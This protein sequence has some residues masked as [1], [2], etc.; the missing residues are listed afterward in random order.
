MNCFAT[1]LKFTSYKSLDSI[2]LTPSGG[3]FSI[4]KEW[5]T[6][7]GLYD[8]GME[9]WGGENIELS[10]RW[11][12]NP[13]PS[14]IYVARPRRRRKER[15]PRSWPLRRIFL[16]PSRPF[17]SDRIDKRIQDLLHREKKEKERQE[18]EDWSDKGIKSVVFFQA[19]FSD[20]ELK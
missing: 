5:F 4:N 15:K 16:H 20:F 19:C 3:L 10:F 12:S 7:L 18:R 6:E 8:E 14:A 17:S 13:S 9:I 2:L 1:L 11:E